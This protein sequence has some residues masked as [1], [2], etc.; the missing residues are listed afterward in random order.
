M[1]ELPQTLVMMGVSGAGKTEVGREVAQRL[2]AVF[3]DAD[4]FH[5]DEAREKMRS[6]QGLTDEDR[7]PWLERL[8][9]RIEAGRAAGR[10]HV[11]ACSALKA[12]YRDVLR[13]GDGGEQL[14]FVLLEGSRELISQR[15][16]ARQGHYMPLSLLDSQ[17]ALLEETP[18]L[19][20][21]TIEGSVPEIAD[22]I[23]MHWTPGQGEGR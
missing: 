2:E 22:L 18:D 19:V 1:E 11:L 23:L 5:T 3:D 20:R 17:L 21:V 4:D 16:G 6:G 14:A 15:M 13:G 8:R 12:V 10:R 7:W 9:S